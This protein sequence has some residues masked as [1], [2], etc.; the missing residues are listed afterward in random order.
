MIEAP[1]TLTPELLRKILPFLGEK[2]VSLILDEINERYDYWTEFKYKKYDSKL[3]NIEL[4]AAARFIRRFH[5]SKIQLTSGDYKEEFCYSVP[6][7]IQEK[8][9]SLDRNYGYIFEEDQLKSE[10]E[11][12]RLQ[13]SSIMEEAIA[14]SQI[15]G[16]ITTRVAAKEMLRSNRRPRNISEQMIFNNYIAILKLN[17]YKKYEL[18]IDLMQEIHATVT[19]DTLENSDHEGRIRYNNEVHVVDTSKSE[20]VHIP[21]GHEYL[22]G[23]LVSFCKFAND[24]KHFIH[25]IVKASILHF[26]VGYLHPF[27]DGNGRTARALFYWFL[28]K[29]DYWLI[30]YVS[31]SK[32]ILKTKIQYAN[33]YQQVERDSNDLTYFIK[34]QIKILE[35][36]FR[37]L[38]NYLTSKR[39]EKRKIGELLRFS[40]FN[41]R[42]IE[43]INK[44]LETEYFEISIKQYEARMNVSFGTARS[45]LL[46]LEDH[47]LFSKI[48]RGKSFYFTPSLE[49]SGRLQ[50]LIISN[51]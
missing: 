42:Q 25:P 41:H 28:L 13:V 5:L 37:E 17:D 48:K 30:E 22:E 31:I 45:D 11:K 6:K 29:N 18:S 40:Q 4:W 1:P 34:Y 39:Q 20:V 24:Q 23:L 44:A 8:L 9:H 49:F 10:R 43:I 51:P 33:A 47:G 46:I 36:S 19:K 27:H 35:A 2:D 7:P 38:K 26:M 15:E 32:L 14:S 21:P 3:S 12:K 50:S 16:A